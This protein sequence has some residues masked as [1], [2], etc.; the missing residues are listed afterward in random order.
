MANSKDLDQ[1]AYE[2]I[3]GS[4]KRVQVLIGIELD[5]RGSKEVALSLWRHSHHGN[6]S[7]VRTNNTGS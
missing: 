7:E 2:Y 4:N 5:Y 1:L 3:C 6:A